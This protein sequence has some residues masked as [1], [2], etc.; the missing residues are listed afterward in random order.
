MTPQEI[1]RRNSTRLDPNPTDVEPRIVRLSGMKAVLFDVYGTLLI[2]GSGDISL[3]SGARHG[4]SAEQAAVHAGLELRD[5]TGEELVDRLHQEIKRQHA[6]S[7]FDYPEVDICQVWRAVLERSV[8]ESELERMPDDHQIAQ[9]AVEYE[10]R[11]NPVWP[12]PGLVEC[13]SAIRARGLPIGIVSNAQAF[14]RD[15]FPPL[16]GCSI[17]ELGFD[18][19]LCVW[20]YAQ[21]QAKP[22]RHLY[23]KAVAALADRGIAASEALYVGNDMRNDIAPAAGVGFRTVLFAGDARSLRLREGDPLTAGVEADA[24]VTDLRQI[25]PILCLAPSPE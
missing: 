9:L 2:S 12:M 25:L 20:S 7:D 10:T 11:V 13:L 22:G 16:T 5:A 24:V 18:R 4:E 23:E 3:T 8:A 17:E 19:E 21:R 14:T 15:L 1:V 6:A